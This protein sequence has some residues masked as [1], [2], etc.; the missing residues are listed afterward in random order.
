MEHKYK[1]EIKTEREEMP[2][3]SQPQLEIN[4]LLI[5][6]FSFPTKQKLGKIGYF[7]N[8]E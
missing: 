2:Y 7:Y 3:S 8:F 4:K 6:D 1:K 5:S